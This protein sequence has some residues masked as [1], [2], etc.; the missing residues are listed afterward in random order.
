MQMSLATNFKTLFSLPLRSL[1]KS[2]DNNDE[3]YVDGSR[4]M[5]VHIVYPQFR[6]KEQASVRNLD[7]HLIVSLLSECETTGGLS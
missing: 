1:K 4:A 6:F 2:K 5:K 3:A 7:R